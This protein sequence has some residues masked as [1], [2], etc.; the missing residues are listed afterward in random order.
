MVITPACWQRKCKHYIGVSQPDGT[1]MSERLVCHA[2]PNGIPDEIVLGDNLHTTPYPGDHGI[3][4][5][6]IDNN[7]VSNAES[8]D[9]MDG[10]QRIL[11]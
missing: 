2:F 9:L 10:L 11:S 1:E 6:L 8:T 7:P 3:Q 5:T 4:Y